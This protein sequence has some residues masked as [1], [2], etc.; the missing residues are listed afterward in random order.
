M[1]KRNRT[2]VNVERAR[3]RCLVASYK[4]AIE[5]G[6]LT[7]ALNIAYDGF[8]ASSLPSDIEGWGRRIVTTK[9]SQTYAA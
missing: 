6:E 4:A 8:F 5:R 1:E 2:Q 3:Q 7:E 9:R